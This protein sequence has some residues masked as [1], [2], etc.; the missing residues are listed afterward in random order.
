MD[1]EYADFIWTDT[2]KQAGWA[3]AIYGGLLVLYW[4]L[5]G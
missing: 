4:T 3:L 1:K 5:I 2:L